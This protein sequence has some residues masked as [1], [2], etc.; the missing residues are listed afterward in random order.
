MKFSTLTTVAFATLASAL[1]IV[2]TNDDT[3]ATANIRAAYHSLKEA[4][5]NVFMVAPVYQQSGKGGTFNLP[6]KPTLE[7]DGEFGSVKAGQPAWGYEEEDNHIWYTDCT[8]AASVSFAL[9]YV[10]P[11]FFAGVP[12]DL[13]IGGPNEGVN[14]GPAVYTLSGTVGSSYY[15][16]SRGIPAI[17]FSASGDEH[18][19]YKDPVH[20]YEI[21]KDNATYPANI[22]AKKIVELV[23]ALDK[24]RGDNPRL[25]PL[26]VGLNVNFPLVGSEVENNACNNP[27]YVNSRL[28][29][30]AWQLR[31]AF[32]ETSGAFGMNILLGDQVPG[33]NAAL[34]GNPNLPGETIASAA[35][36]CKASISVYSVD[37]DANIQLEEETRYLFKSVIA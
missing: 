29:G 15:A 36:T 19:Y 26:G 35:N 33:I 25:L 24:A 23:N 28:T 27:E 1:N 14:V 13:V 12:I 30:G 20:G 18:I 34:N 9:D 22:H 5:H 2:I 16:V 10:I 32:N 6:T 8:P 7:K 37:Y 31:V 21:N 17:A 3:F 11:N 4:G